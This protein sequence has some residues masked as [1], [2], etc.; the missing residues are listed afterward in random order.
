MAKRILI[1]SGSPRKGGNTM[2]VVK[3]V[4]DGASAAG[5]E[6][7]IVDAARLNYKA[8][9]CTSC[10]SCQNSEAYVCAVKDDAAELLA[11][12]PKYD[13]VV[14]AT[15]VFFMGF[16][17]QLKHIVDRM[18]SLVKIDHE[19]HTVKHALNDVEFALI[20]TAGGGEGSGLNLVKANIDAICGF[21]GKKPRKFCV[22]FAPFQS[23][24]LDLDGEL[25]AKSEAFGAALA[26]DAPND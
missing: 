25:R 6:V 3:W 5:A 14:L 23:G 11:R 18:Y 15:P 9:G 4:A 8:P 10:M 16:S 20:A 12:F 19:K 26:S 24:E 21:L 17:A 2:T 7:E 13:V 22:P 1:V